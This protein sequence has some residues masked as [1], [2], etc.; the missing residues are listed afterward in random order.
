MMVGSEVKGKAAGASL[1]LLGL[2]ALTCVHLH[3][4]TVVYTVAGLPYEGLPHMNECART[5]QPIIVQSIEGGQF[6]PRK[7]IGKQRTKRT[8]VRK[9]V[10]T[11]PESCGSA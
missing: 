1:T 6:T 10:N 2:T 11:I 3:L 5:I 4:C 8:A 9:A 7:T